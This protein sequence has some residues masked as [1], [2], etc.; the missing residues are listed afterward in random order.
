MKKLL[1]IFAIVMFG[2]NANSQN[3]NAGANIGLPVG[4]AGDLATF[5]IAIDLGYLFEISEDFSAGVGTGYVHMF[6]KEE[7]GFEYEDIQ[8]L[9]V[10]AKAEVDLS[11]KFSL[12]A[13]VGYA[14][15]LGD[16]GGGDFY[17]RPGAYYH[18]NDQTSINI[19]FRNV[20]GDGST[21]STAELGVRF[22][23]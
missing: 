3:F 6:G 1:F 23:F 21:L 18:L 8:F 11:D 20:S 15:N 13:D 7:N 17:Y 16:G 22:R 19:G 5:A 12:G 10:A 9:P 14:F 4:D 2:F